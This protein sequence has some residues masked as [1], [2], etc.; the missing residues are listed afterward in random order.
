MGNKDK[1]ML[2][3]AFIAICF[4]GFITIK[5][6]PGKGK[7]LSGTGYYTSDETTTIGKR[8]GSS[9][10]SLTKTGRVEC[11]GLDNNTPE[12]ELIRTSGATTSANF[13]G[14]VYL[15]FTE[16]CLNLGT[17]SIN[18]SNVSKYIPD[19]TGPTLTAYF[20]NASYPLGDNC[21]EIVAPFAY[22]FVTTNF[23]VSNNNTITIINKSGTCKMIVSNP[24]NWF[25]AGKYGTETVY[26][27]T[28]DPAPW[29]EHNNHHITKVG[30]GSNG[31][32]SGSPG[33]LIG[34]GNAGTE[35]TFYAY[36]GGT[37]QN[38]SINKLCRTARIE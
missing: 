14:V 7:I 18:K 29:E 12:G 1:I 8:E 6:Y 35:I 11:P 27:N 19:T 13:Y 37:W 38:I 16:D 26:S 4:V 32:E 2:V 5:N 17:T 31:Y 30:Y 24:A 36:S 33:D 23:D 15:P 22:S 9:Y 28:N 25:C 34:Y 10:S 3:L 21:Y 20:E